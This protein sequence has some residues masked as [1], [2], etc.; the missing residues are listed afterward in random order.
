MLDLL[1]EKLPESVMLNIQYRMHNAILAFSNKMFYGGL[2]S[3]HEKVQFHHLPGDQQPLIFVDTAGCGF[4][5]KL[6]PQHQ[7]LRNEGEF[8]LIR[9]ILLL[10][11][12]SFQGFSVGIISPYAD[13]VRFIREELAQDA[14]LHYTTMEVDTIDGFQGQE[15][16]IIFI[17]LV[18]SNERSEIGFLKD[19]RRL[20]VAMTRARKKLVIVGD[21]AT[22]GAHPLYNELISHINEHGLYES[23]WNYM[24]W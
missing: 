15:K 6:H 2:L 13:Q 23:G 3:G 9:E 5:E 18:R 22:L 24:S 14:S 11:K 20:N 4:E 10:K 8:F 1:A 7:S 21:S 19:E 16:D 12:E 17:S